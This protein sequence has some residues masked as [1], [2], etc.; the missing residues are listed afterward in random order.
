[1]SASGIN[2]AQGGSHLEEFDAVVVGAG[3]GGIYLLYNLRKLGYRVK[4]LEAGKDLGGVWRANSY[5]GARVDTYWP[6]YEFSAR[7]LW[8]DWTW[9]ERFP[10]RDELCRYFDY[11][12]QKWDIK[13]DITFDQTVTK[14]KYDQ[15]LN[16][17]ITTTDTGYVAKSRFLLLA[18][19]FA[20]KHYIPPLN[21]LDNFRG[22][23]HHTALWPKEGQDLRGKR[24]GVIGTGASGVQVIQEIAPVVE[25][26]AVFQRTANN[27]LPMRQEKH[28]E[29]ALELQQEAKKGYEDL[30]KLSMST[31]AGWDYDGHNRSSI[32]DSPEDQIAHMESLWT[33]GGFHMWLGNYNNLL[34]DAKFNNS[35][36]RFWRDKV[37]ERLPNVD[38]ETVESLAPWEPENPFG[39]KRPSLEQRYYEVYTRPNVKLYNIRRNPISE[40][41]SHGLKMTSGEEVEVDILILATGFD[42]VTGSLLKIELQGVDGVKLSDKWAQG[43]YT[44][45]GMATAGFPNMFF[46]YGPQGP[47]AFAIGPRIA[48]LQGGWII[49][50]LEDMKRHH[51]SRIE[52]LPAAEVEWRTETNDMANKSLLSKANTWY[53]GSNIPGKPRE[54]LN[55][56]GGMP[57]YAGIIQTRAANGYAGF[58]VSA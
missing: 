27:A 58:T 4:V 6:L 11:V 50:C 45:L 57:K 54:A 33:K 12:D 17:W 23:V 56:M 10:G 42:A 24:V 41:T 1:M 36:H 9:A 52:A 48:E 55:Y 16:I 25:H 7:E 13:K 38:P 29:R 19:G 46:M 3:F 32:E 21:G 20:A 31:Y 39:T 8:E 5:P 40:I 26:L 35:V 53:M 44:Y 15:I 51:K 47:T 34:T 28:D 43:A 2:T 18:T 37:R 14:A 30:F 22:I 49:S